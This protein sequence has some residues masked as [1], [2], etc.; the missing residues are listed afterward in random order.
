MKYGFFDD[1]S[2]EYVISTHCTPW[3]WINYLGSEGYFSLVSNTMGGYSFFRDARF[4]RITRYIYNNNFPDTHGR[5]FYIKERDHIWNPGWKPSKTVLDSYECRHGLGYSR[6]K[7]SKNDLQAEVL[8]LVPPGF[9]GEVFCLKLNNT[10]Q[11][12]KNFSVYTYLEWCL[13]NA[14]DDMTNYQRTYSIGR[15]EAMGNAIVHFTDYKDRRDH[16]AFLSASEPFQG[17]DCEREVFFGVHGGPDRPEMVVSGTSGQSSAFGWNPVAVQRFDIIL[18][19][20]ES[21]ELYFCLGY[22]ENAPGE[23]WV[24]GGEISLKEMQQMVSLYDNAV[25]FSQAMEQLK[26]FW[27]GLL[28]VYQVNTGNEHVRRMVNIW[29][30]YQCMV[31]FNMSR[32]ASYFETGIG[33]GLGFRDSNQDLLGFVH[34]VPRR[35]RQRLIDLASTQLPDGGAY[36]QYQPLTKRGNHEIGGNFNDDPLWMICGTVA[37]LKETGDFSILDEKVPFDNDP[38]QS[39][40]MFEHLKRSFRYTLKNLGP[41]GLPLIGRADWNDCMNL[42]IFNEDPDVSFQ[43]GPLKRDGQTA[44]SLMI[45]GAFVLYGKQ[46]AELCELLGK[47]EEAGK[48]REHIQRMEEKIIEHGWDG[49]WFLRAWDADGRKVG[50]KENEEGKIFIESQGFCGMAGIGKESG[51]LE[52]ALDSVKKFLDCPYGIVLQNPAFTKYYIEYGEISTYIPGYKE[53]AGIFCHNNP[54]IMIAET[55]LG[56]GENAYAYWEKICPSAIEVISDLHRTEPYVYSQMIAGKDAHRPGEAKNS[57]LTGTAAWNF[58]AITQY[59]LGIRPHWNGLVIDPCIPPQWDGFS[60]TRLFRE[61]IYDI[62]VTNPEHVCKGIRQITLN[63]KIVEGNTLPLL[64]K[65]EQGK[66]EVLMGR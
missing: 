38:A 62:R 2:R 1:V 63:G 52:K 43:T 20:G 23:K 57:W 50:S 25:K 35:A 22:V 64:K 28:S 39:A 12:E 33:R 14:L 26:A 34:Q 16:Y 17:F 37:Y 30:P 66:V 8:Q 32:S 55:V 5:Y 42:N 29:N 56:R 18:S 13:W 21:K 46:Y 27:D 3:P 47:K 40:G 54:W 11:Q 31:T 10:G 51:M 36:H 45:A 61:A 53:N 58:V 60:V 65:E 59:I 7:G 19:P 49:E 4:R 6:F 44:E 24:A 15:A 9:R 41:H 48:A